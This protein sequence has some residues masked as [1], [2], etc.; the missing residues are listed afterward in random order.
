[1]GTIA[2]E[3]TLPFSLFV[4]FLNGVNSVKHGFNSKGSKQINGR[5]MEVCQLTVIK[6][7]G[8]LFYLY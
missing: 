5:N 8:S 3:A 2:G 7:A 1:M 4:S 6:A